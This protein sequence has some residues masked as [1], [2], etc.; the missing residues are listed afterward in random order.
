[1]KTTVSSYTVVKTTINLRSCGINLRFG[2]DLS[3]FRVYVVYILLRS[4]VTKVEV[5]SCGKITRV[6]SDNT[7]NVTAPVDVN[8]VITDANFDD[9]LRAGGV[10]ESAFSTFHVLVSLFLQI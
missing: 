4:Y 6:F 10:A 8:D 7:V 1:M 3:N 5:M 9:R 2:L